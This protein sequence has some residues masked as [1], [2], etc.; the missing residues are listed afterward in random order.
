MFRDDSDRRSFCTRL[1]K[2]MARHAWVCHAFVLMHTH[3]HLL[4]SV[5]DDVLQPGMRDAFGPYAQ[6]FNR[7]WD[8]SGHLR[9]APYGLRRIR[10]DRDLHGAVRY[11][12]RNP[13]RAKLC[14]VPQEWVWGSYRGSAGYDR[15]FPFV[16]DRIALGSL[17]D[18][19]GRAV[20]ILRY[21]VEIS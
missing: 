18:N 19:R 17:D 14:A 4:V 12:A 6:E 10:D 5:G 9:G 3:F 11:I 1:M 7:R 21:I 8:R 13:V 20:E 16:D 15:P 2:S